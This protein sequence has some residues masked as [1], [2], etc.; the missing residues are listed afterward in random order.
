M[1]YNS[2]VC[3]ITASNKR[4]YTAKLHFL[5]KPGVRLNKPRQFHNWFLTREL[6]I[7]LEF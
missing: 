3:V 1:P 4:I 5:V 7:N 2:L 6:A